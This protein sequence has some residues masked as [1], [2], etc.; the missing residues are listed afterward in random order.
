MGNRA[1][2]EED[3]VILIL[4]AQGVNLDGSEEKM[5]QIWEVFSHYENSLANFGD[6]HTGNSHTTSMKTLLTSSS[7][8]SHAVFK[9]AETLKNCLEALKEGDFGISVVVSGLYDSIKSICSEIGLK[10]H[11]VQHSLGI[12]GRTDLLPMQ[13]KL[14][15][16]TLCGHAM[17]SANLIEKLVKEIKENKTTYKAAAD[18]LSRLCDCGV[19]NPHQAEKILK[20]MVTEIDL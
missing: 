7:R 3:F 5:R 18:E 17:I 13:D 12:H 8:I 19:F 1:D 15:I 2:L 4:P 6:G 11:T 16:M 14:Q 9:D 20:R 10:P